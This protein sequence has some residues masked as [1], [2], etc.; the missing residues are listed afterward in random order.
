M[1]LPDFLVI[2]AMKAG[3]TSLFHYL[4]QH[5]QLAFGQAKEPSLFAF[6]DSPLVFS[7]PLD[8]RLKQVVITD[9]GA[10]KQ[11]YQGVKPG[12]KLGD[13]SPIYMYSERAAARIHECIPHA[14]LIAILRDPADRAYSNYV[15][16]A[17]EGRE[18][19]AT[20]EAALEQEE[21]RITANWAPQWH[22]QKLGFY[23]AQLKRY[24]ALF[25]RAQMRFFLYEDLRRDEP[26]VLH[27]IFDFLGVDSAFVPRL[28]QRWNVGGVVK[29]RAVHNFLRRP[30]WVGRLVRPIVPRETRQRIV[31][32]LMRLNLRPAPPMRAETRERLVGAYRPDIEELQRLIDRDLDAWLRI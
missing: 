8:D 11:Q 3:T 18:P 4:R 30:G 21:A 25:P 26:G 16:F 27:Q 22:Y 32:R 14:Q 9:L 17:R 24:M 19:A 12:M 29:S 7:G 31:L 13:V 2:G 23:A 6:E 15:H 28:G 20:F 10:Y 5:P 1:P